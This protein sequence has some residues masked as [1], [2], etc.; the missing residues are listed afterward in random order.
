MTEKASGTYGLEYTSKEVSF[1]LLEDEEPLPFDGD[2]VG[3]LDVA[4][5]EDLS[6]ST[7]S[8]AVAHVVS[9]GFLLI[10]TTFP[11][12]GCFVVMGRL[13]RAAMMVIRSLQ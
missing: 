10:S 5:S 6:P 7:L 2:D 13:T 3:D 4:I 9:G 8:I 11:S 12:S 1:P